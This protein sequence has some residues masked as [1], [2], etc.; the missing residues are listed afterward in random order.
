MN[1]YLAVETESVL[2]TTTSCLGG[3]QV[4][5]A[6]GAVTG[7][8]DTIT[9]ARYHFYTAYKKHLATMR[10]LDDQTPSQIS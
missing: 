2:V 6:D 3:Y 9:R 7:Y 10:E 5:S 1:S 8:G 4:V